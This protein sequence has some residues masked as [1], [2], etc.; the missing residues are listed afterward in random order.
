MVLC[1]DRQPFVGR[2]QTGSFGDGPAQQDALEF[3]PE[4]IVQTGGIM[5]LDQVREFLRF[6]PLPVRAGFGRLPKSRLRLYS[7][8][9]IYP[10]L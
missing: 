7:S 10:P 8:S 6:V 9:A 3:Q 4:V 5:L 1:P 2:I